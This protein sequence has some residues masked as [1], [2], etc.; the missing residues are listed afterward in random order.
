MLDVALKRAE[1]GWSVVALQRTADPEG[2]LQGA[3][4]E[5]EA[6]DDVSS[7]LFEHQLTEVVEFLTNV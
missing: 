5:K 6:S 4:T 2:Q 3:H 1:S 7:A